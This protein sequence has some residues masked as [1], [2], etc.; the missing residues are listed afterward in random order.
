MLLPV[1]D[2]SPL[3]RCRRHHNPVLSPASQH[4]R[5]EQPGCRWLK[6]IPAGT[7]VW[8]GFSFQ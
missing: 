3:P 1:H 7:G 2:P 6:I 5:Y 4:G 8:R